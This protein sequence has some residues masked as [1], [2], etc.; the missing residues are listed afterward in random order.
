MRTLIFASCA[1]FALPLAAEAQSCRGIQAFD[2]GGGTKGCVVSIQ[3]NQI[4]TTTSRDD[5]AST[6][7]RRN[8]QPLVGAVMSG[9]VPANKSVVKKQMVEMC[10][11]TQEKVR[12]QF[13]D[14]KYNRVIL[15]MDWQ[16]AGGEVQ[17]GFSSA[18]CRGFKFFDG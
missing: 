6:R 15:V 10:K 16:K 8:A 9:P 3:E 5:G 17:A 18:K 1:L 4:T 7:V 14:L 12:A 2:L 13:A 11:L